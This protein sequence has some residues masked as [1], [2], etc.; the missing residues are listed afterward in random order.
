MTGVPFPVVVRA[1]DADWNTVGSASDVVRL[2]STAGN[3]VLPAP[4]VL[5]GGQVTFEVVLPA[6]GSSRFTAQDQTNL[7]IPL[8]TSAN[9]TAVAL[10]GFRFQDVAPHERQ[11]GSAFVTSLTAIDAG[12]NVVL[13]YHGPVQLEQLTSLG[14]G[15]VEPARDHAGQRRLERQ[16]DGLPRRRIELAARQRPRARA[17]AGRS[18]PQRHRRPVRR[19]SGPARATAA[20]GAGHDRVPGQRRRLRR[21]AGEPGGDGAVH[22]SVQATDE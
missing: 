19:A 11:A 13:G 2:T 1:C 17:P 21:R 9:V 14:L 5:I 18:R 16:P 20:A 7:L 15:R 12:G 6:A 8:G 22:V 3:A 10:A 4:S